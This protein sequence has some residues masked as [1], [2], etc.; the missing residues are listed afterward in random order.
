MHDKRNN[1]TKDYW[2]EY[3]V[4]LAEMAKLDLETRPEV[5]FVYPYCGGQGLRKAGPG[6]LAQRTPGQGRGGL[7]RK[8]VLWDTD[9]NWQV[10]FGP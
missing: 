8:Q 9:L 2:S 3:H 7:V 5:E 6:P 10:E 1:G 4:I